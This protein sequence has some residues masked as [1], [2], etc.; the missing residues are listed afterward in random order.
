MKRIKIL[1]TMFTAVTAMILLAGIPALKVSAEERATYNIY[2]DP[3]GY[4]WTV[5]AGIKAEYESEEPPKAMQFFYNNV[6]DGD[7]VVITCKHENTPLLDLGTARLGN[8]TIMHDTPFFMIKTAGVVDFF[9]L[10]KSSC[11]ITGSV[12]NAYVYD[13]ALVNFNSNV[14]DI[15]LNVDEP[16]SSTIMGCSG[17][18]GSLKV[19][20]TRDN[21]S[22]SVY[23]FKKDT[24]LFSD[25]RIKTSPADFGGQPLPEISAPV[26]VPA[27]GYKLKDVFDER[28]YADRYQD[29]KNAFGYDREA[30]WT[31]FMTHGMKEGRVMNTLLDVVKYRATY[32]DLNDAFGEN[33]DAYV[34]HFLTNG[35]RE[36]RDSGTEFDAYDYALKF[37]DM[38]ITYGGNILPVWQHYNTYGRTLAN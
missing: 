12:S 22:Y 21:S 16:E 33:W 19:V 6:K 15:I 38:R 13:P 4:G 5:L 14:K 11:A 28:Y 9:A 34:N 3:D 30:L 20:F 35:A 7:A 32:K 31:H 18:V 10:A 2:Y 37:D 26:P 23:N 29:L 25:G 8:I 17:V 36:G 27:G 1:V 24:F